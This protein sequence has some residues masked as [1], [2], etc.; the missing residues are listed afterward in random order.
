MA[1]EIAEPE[2]IPQEPSKKIIFY[3]V[4]SHIPSCPF[5]TM[6][7]FDPTSLQVNGGKGKNFCVNKKC[8]LVLNFLSNFQDPICG[9]GQQSVAFW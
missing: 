2:K 7:M 4:Q 5:A 3:W 9:N 1:N 8:Q 6:A